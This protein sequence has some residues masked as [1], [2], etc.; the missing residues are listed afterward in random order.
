MLLNKNKKRTYEFQNCEMNLVLEN[1][2]VEYIDEDKKK[3]G[4][5]LAFFREKNGRGALQISTLTS[6][7]KKFEI[8]EILEKNGQANLDLKE[9]KLKGWKL[10]ET[11]KNEDGKYFK[12]FY[13]LKPYIVVYAT[14]N[15][16]SEYLSDK[17]PSEAKKIVHSIEVINKK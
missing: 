13:L 5:P 15:C 9:D 7:Y 12:Y 2:W 10:Y 14:Y 17:E 4:L 6:E 11:E 8:K 16:A 3:Y 1:G